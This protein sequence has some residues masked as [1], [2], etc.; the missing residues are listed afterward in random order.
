MLAE[1]CLLVCPEHVVSLVPRVL[2]ETCFLVESTLVGL[3]HL[4]HGVVIHL[5]GV[6]AEERGS[7]GIE[8]QSHEDAVEPYLLLVNGLVPPHSLVCA[9]LLLK[10]SEESFYGC[11]VLL[12]RIELLPAQHEFSRAHL[13]EIVVLYLVSLDVALLVNHLLTVFFQ[14]RNNALIVVNQSSIEHPFHFYSH[15]VTP[16]RLFRKVKHVGVMNSLHFRVCHPHAVCGVG[17]IT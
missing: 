8:R 17:E 6:L 5:L 3:C 4:H 13:V 15:D 10:L 7:G 16:P 12:L 11:E 9:R 1:S 14:I 2:P